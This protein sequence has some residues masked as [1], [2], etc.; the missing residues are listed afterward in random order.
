MRLRSDRH[1]A[2]AGS[3]R[4]AGRA[5]LHLARRRAADFAPFKAAVEPYL[6]PHDL[7]NAKLAYSS[8]VVGKANWKLVMENSRECYHCPTGHP[9]LMRSFHINYDPAGDARPPPSGSA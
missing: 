1:R 2:E 6:A 9:E 7:A 4:D 8:D 3:C 5:H